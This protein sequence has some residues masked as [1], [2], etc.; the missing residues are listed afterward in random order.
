[1]HAV[2]SQSF[3]FY[4]G[5]KHIVNLG[6][7]DGRK[8][9][10]ENKDFSVSQGFVE[11]LTGLVSSNDARDDYGAA[12]FVKCVSVL[13]RGERVAQTLAVLTSDTRK[14]CDELVARPASVLHQE[15]Q[16]TDVTQSVYFLLYRLVQRSVGATEISE[17]DRLLR[18]TLRIFESFERN[19]SLAHI[20][21]PWLITPKYV[22]RYIAGARLYIAIR[23]ILNRR[24]KAGHREEDA[25]QY[26]YDQNNDTDK[27]VRFIFS[28]LASSVT[29]TGAAATWLP[30]FLSDAPEWQER[31]REEVDA[32]V[33]K[34]RKDPT[35]SPND[36]LA[37]LSL[38]IWESDFPILHSCLQETLRIT[39]TGTFFRKN[40]S[41]S[42]IP[43]GDSGDVVPDG[44]YATYLPDSVHMDPR[45]YPDP[46]EFNPARFHDARISEEEEPHTFL[47]WGSGRHLCAGMR[48]AKVQIN[49]ILVHMLANFDFELSDEK[50][51]QKL[52]T[53]P[54]VDRNLL[55]PEKS[56]VPIYIRYKRR[57]LV[58]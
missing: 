34:Y 41:G 9:F 36:V 15:W 8:T 50:G 7:L 55:R 54:S 37:T 6:G 48:L 38:Q 20:I 14:F 44:S 47:G 43:L 16:V 31:C 12:F 40:V 53:M 35:Q 52:G 28:A 23:R 22:A 29:M 18:H 1:M 13:S 57:N 5:K 25:L 58:A 26:V 51:R 46:L 21:F 4:V 3:S 24:N 33:F 42:D 2:P 11:L 17:D 19:T 27:V 10:F 39:S 45:V 49:I 56:H 30:A 32:V